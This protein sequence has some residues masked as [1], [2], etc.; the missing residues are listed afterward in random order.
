[1]KTYFDA[2]AF[3]LVLGTGLLVLPPL[4]SSDDWLLFVLGVVMLFALPVALWFVSKNFL[5]KQG[6]IK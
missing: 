6:W 2:V 4:I 5:K 3:I 1:M